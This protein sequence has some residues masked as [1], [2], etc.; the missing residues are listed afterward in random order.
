MGS[1]IKEQLGTKNCY[2]YRSRLLIAGKFPFSCT[3][4]VS[5]VEQGGTTDSTHGLA[6]IKDLSYQMSDLR[7]RFRIVD[8]AFVDTTPTGPESLGESAEPS[9]GESKRPPYSLVV[10]IHYF[11]GGDRCFVNV[12][13][14]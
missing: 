4:N 7:F 14:I 11:Q 6:V 8:E 10:C 3:P 5:Q 9:D 1:D 2:V 12:I 13:K